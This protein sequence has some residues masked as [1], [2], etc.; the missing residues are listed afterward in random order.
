MQIRVSRVTRGEK[1]YEYAQLVES[2]RRED[3][4]PSHR[5]IAH[6]GA[7]SGAEI[8]NLK[9]AIAANRDGKHV[10]L[11]RPA[12]LA[13][14]LPK[15]AANLRYLD[16]AVLLEVWKQWR[17]PEI[18]DEVLPPGEADVSL[19]SVVAALAIQ[20][21]VDPGSKLYFTQWFPR[22]ALP[23]LLGVSS[24]K[25]NNTRVHR[26]LDGLDAATPALMAK[27]PRRY[28]DAGDGAFSALFLDVTDTWFVG[29]GPE[30]AEL[31]KTKEGFVKRKVG[32]VLLCNEHG[33]PL[34][35]EVVPGAAHDSKTM[36]EMVEA[37]SK[38][39]WVGEA[40]IVCDR[41]MGKTAQL[42]TLALSGL[43]FLTALTLPEFGAYAELPDVELSADVEAAVRAVT[44]AGMEKVQDNLYVKDLGTVE[45]T[46]DG[47]TGTGAA[48]STS[49]QQAMQL[50][51][52]VRE[53][54]DGGQHV[55]Y[56]A[57]ARALG[58]SKQLASKYV[59]LC[60]LDESIQRTILDGGAQGCTLAEL[61][62]IARTPPDE[63][64]AAFAHVKDSPVPRRDPVS[65]DSHAKQPLVSFT[66]RVLGYFNPE[67][68]VEQRA[69]GRRHIE[70]VRAFIESLNTALA[71]PRSRRTR[72]N[73][74]AAV[75]HCLRE[76]DLL[77]AYAVTIDEQLVAGRT[78]FA[79]KIELNEA[80]WA[81]RRRYD[82]FTLLV[83]HP[84]LG[85]TAIE[86]CRLYRAKDTV[87]KDFQVIKSV[88]ELRPMH[89]RT[90][91]KVRAHVTLCMLALLLERTLQRKLNGT[92][93][94]EAALELLAPCHINRFVGDHPI[95]SMT[96]PTEEQRDILRALR[97]DRL[98]SDDII[99]G[100]IP[101]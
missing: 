56:A 27:L 64:P 29:G 90:D 47:G 18:L 88:V 65:G 39:T 94:A 93:S 58:L 45:R 57:A 34:R 17:L 59:G 67:R 86:L 48:T 77:G 70:K 12:R 80:E 14:A 62:A 28:L 99:E 32:I 16:V 84:A 25:F 71:G 38:L 6:L 101:R 75:D 72:D 4:S 31:G 54:V 10:V 66:V 85:A 100:L 43:R 78:R 76:Y 1:K 30:M 63:Q 96:Q 98:V 9:V 15:V 50:A 41:A 37:I 23:E 24:A 55:S 33:Y 52:Q 95:Y 82:G 87:E 92:R 42:R 81:R 20:R 79:V 36:T 13:T 40:P 91:G 35:W 3:G 51:R 44:A 73:V 53:L 5:V 69:K 22:S 60:K 8:A 68:F 21:C 89:H 74:V 49:P 61:L 26:V 83:A 19:A 46:E 11:A 2:F 97:M 7:L